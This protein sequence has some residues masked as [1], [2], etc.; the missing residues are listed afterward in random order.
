M[1]THIISMII[2]V[3]QDQDSQGLY[4]VTL[5]LMSIPI[6]WLISKWEKTRNLEDGTYR[7]D[8]Y[9][10]KTLIELQNRRKEAAIKEQKEDTPDEKKDK[11]ER[12]RRLVR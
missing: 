4:M 7:H 10:V 1:R 6:L 12:R 11:S 2:A 5:I 8:F 9:D 3:T